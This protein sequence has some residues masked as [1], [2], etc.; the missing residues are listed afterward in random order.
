MFTIWFRFNGSGNGHPLEK[1]GIDT[2]LIVIAV[3]IIRYL[4]LYILA[5]NSKME[6]R[7]QN[8]VIRK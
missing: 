4:Q 5:L 6:I 2:A 7:N 3:L 1:D 8:K